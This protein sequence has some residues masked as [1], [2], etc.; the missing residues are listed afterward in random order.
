MSQWQPEGKLVHLLAKPNQTKQFYCLYFVLLRKSTTY[1]HYSFLLVSPFICYS[2]Y[3]GQ[4]SIYMCRYPSN[5]RDHV[6]S[7]SKERDLSSWM[8]PNGGGSLSL[9]IIWCLCSWNKKK[10]LSNWLAGFLPPY[11]LPTLFEMRRSYTSQ[12]PFCLMSMLTCM[13]W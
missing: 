1:N 2:N 12:K 5:H 11:K 3:Q 7:E 8:S 10:F 9:F 4:I 6:W 13:C